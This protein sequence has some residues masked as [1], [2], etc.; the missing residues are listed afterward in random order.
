M[1]TGW[2]LP[3]L[4]DKKELYAN[5]EQPWRIICGRTNNVY[6]AEL[7]DLYPELFAQWSKR[8]PQTSSDPHAAADAT[9][10]RG[11]GLDHHKLKVYIAKKAT[12]T[13]AKATPPIQYAFR[14]QTHGGNASSAP[15]AT[16]AVLHFHA[17]SA[18]VLDW[19]GTHRARNQRQVF[20]A[21]P[22]LF[23]GWRTVRCQGS[24]PAT[25]IS[26][27]WPSSATR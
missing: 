20:Q 2:P 1:A 17:I 10:S 25:S 3:H 23:Q 14:L 21:I 5:A 18:D 15:Q 22:A 4:S 11:R 12:T 6:S 26:T 7:R 13:P 9:C 16:Q 19:A 8:Y 27:R 24:P